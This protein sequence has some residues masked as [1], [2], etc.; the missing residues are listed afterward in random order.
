M[1]KSILLSILFLSSFAAM[2]YD[3]DSDI[4]W[5]ENIEN[6]FDAE[7]AAKSLNVFKMRKL[8]APD[9]DSFIEAAISKD[10]VEN[11]ENI[12]KV[13]NYTLLMH[14][15]ETK[16]KN[17]FV[18]VDKNHVEKWAKH[19]EGYKETSLPPKTL[20]YEIM[21]ADKEKRDEDLDDWINELKKAPRD[22]EALEEINRLRP[23]LRERVLKTSFMIHIFEKH[24]KNNFNYLPMRFTTLCSDA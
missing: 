17:D 7:E 21:S 22:R 16:T 15:F 4:D 13:E 5:R 9:P 6:T 24:E 2:G 14:L 20:V 12:E 19:F 18:G 1:K 8:L 11:A 3:S 10:F 23:E